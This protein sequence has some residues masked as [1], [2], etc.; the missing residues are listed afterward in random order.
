MP[1]AIAELEAMH[2]L[3]G[4][5]TYGVASLG[6]A[7]THAG[8]TNKAQKVLGQLL[9]L[10]GQGSDRRV[11]IALVQHG[12][13]D[14]G[15]ALDSLDMAFAERASGLERVNYEPGWKHLRPHPRGQAILKKMNLVK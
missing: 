10:Q 9:E 11:G 4:N 3:N 15:R 1:E 13:G 7:Y 12:L 5:G 6:I 8:R 2:R 14:D